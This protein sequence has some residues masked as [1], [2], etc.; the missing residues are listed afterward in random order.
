M[1]DTK[2]LMKEVQEEMQTLL[3]EY[4]EQMKGF[5]HFLEAVEKDGALKR[6]D[7]ELIAIA[8]SVITHCRWC[9][10]FHVKTALN[11]GASKEEITE[12]AWAAALMGGGPALMYMQLVL[13]AL[14]DYE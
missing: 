1:E 5:Q 9:I 4:P 7:K 13:K 6:K 2:E 11:A 8:L 12:A 3:Q 10:A 14:K